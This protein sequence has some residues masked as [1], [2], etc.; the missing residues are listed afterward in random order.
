MANLT[1]N[2][3]VLDFV[4]SRVD[5]CKPDK[6]VWI[7]GSDE[8]Y[9]QLTEQALATGEMI[10]LNQEVLPGCLLHRTAVNDVARVEGRT[11]IC[12]R[13]KKIPRKHILCSTPFWT[14]LT[15]AERCTS[16]L[17]LWVPSAALSP[18]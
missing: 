8:L 7:D 4:Q 15:R 16:F 6:V 14:A 17:T 10:K 1:T 2:K 11:F 3:Q 5:L 12:A 13:T 9:A 18:R